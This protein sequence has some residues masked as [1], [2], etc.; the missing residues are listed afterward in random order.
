VQEVPFPSCVSDRFGL[1]LR[2]RKFLPR[3]N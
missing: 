2:E 1:L 3:Q